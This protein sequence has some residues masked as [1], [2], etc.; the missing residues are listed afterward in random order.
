MMEIPMSTRHYC[1][2]AA[3]IAMLLACGG[4]GSEEEASDTAPKITRFFVSPVRI[5]L[6]NNEKLGGTVDFEDPDGDVE[7]LVLQLTGPSGEPEAPLEFELP[8]L[9]GQTKGNID[10]PETDL[11]V[12]ASGTYRV[13][14]WLEDGQSQRSNI[15]D[16]EIEVIITQTSACGLDST[17]CGDGEFCYDVMAPT[18]EYATEHNLTLPE[19]AELTDEAPVAAGCRSSLE[20]PASSPYK[21]HQCE[22]VQFW[23]NPTNL[24]ADCR[25]GDANVHI[26]RCSR[27]VDQ[28]LEVSFGEG[29]QMRAV[30]SGIIDNGQGDVIGRELYMPMSWSDGT[31]QDS[32]MIFAINLDTGDRRH[33]S[34][35]HVDPREGIKEVGSGDPFTEIFQVVAGEDGM[36]YVI[37]SKTEAGEPRIWMV[38]PDSGERTLLYDAETVEEEKRCANGNLNPGGRTDLQLHPGSFAVDGDGNFYISGLPTSLPGPA[39][40]KIDR[41]TNQCDYVTL[42]AVGG[43][44]NEAESVGGGYSQ[45]QFPFRGLEWNDGKLYAISN[46]QLHEIDPATGDRRLLSNAKT[47]GGLGSGPVADEGLGNYWTVYDKHHDVFWTVGGGGGFVVAVDPESGDRF[48]FPCWHPGLGIQGSLC[49]TTGKMVPGSLDNGGLVVDPDNPRNLFILHDLISVV[50]YDK[51]TS[52]AITFSL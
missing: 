49:N 38:D 9:V 34:G 18:C 10:I 46:T 32:G 19:C 33:I 17:M 1:A 43:T 31:T 21:E 5:Q 26:D 24:M 16:R 48:T 12:M 35:T 51:Q 22:F 6:G 27:P 13:D 2:L 40:V 29:P 20:D 52:N 8:E 44:L 23:S 4:A 7:R 47:T 37:G 15:M 11:T 14:A 36:L 50:R 28:P 25:C 45:V 3:T 39:I 42:V 30:S 41:Q